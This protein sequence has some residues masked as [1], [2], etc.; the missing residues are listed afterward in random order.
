MPTG[1]LSSLA[2]VLE[3]RTMRREHGM[4]FQT[5]ITESDAGITELKHI[6]REK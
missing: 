6:I 4:K 1:W 5:R 3:R 2:S